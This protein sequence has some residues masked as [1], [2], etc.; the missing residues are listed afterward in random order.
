MEELAASLGIAT[1]ETIN[2]WARQGARTLEDMPPHA[3][4]QFDDMMN[5]G[6]TSAPSPSER[7]AFSFFDDEGDAASDSTEDMPVSEVSGLMAL[8]REVIQKCAEFCSFDFVVIS[9]RCVSKAMCKAAGCALT[10][11]RWAP[12]RYHGANLVG[13]LGGPREGGRIRGGNCISQG[14]GRR[15]RRAEN[16]G[17]E[18]PERRRRQGAVGGHGSHRRQTR[19]AASRRGQA[20]QSI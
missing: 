19:L 15:A 11:G 10:R 13:Q 8:P 5:F 20:G 7:V 16:A 3:L 4:A 17:A 14:G 2:E 1:K 18:R 6:R 9:L 12:I